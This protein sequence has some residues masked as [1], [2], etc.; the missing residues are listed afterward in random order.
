MRSTVLKVCSLGKPVF[1]HLVSSGLH[2][3]DLH[4]AL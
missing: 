2:L 3:S 1:S 4:L